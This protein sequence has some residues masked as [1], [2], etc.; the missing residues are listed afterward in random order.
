[1]AMEIL[2]IGEQLELFAKVCKASSDAHKMDKLT[3]ELLEKENERLKKAL[4]L[5]HTE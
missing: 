4:S 3:I 5:Q 2:N 1:M